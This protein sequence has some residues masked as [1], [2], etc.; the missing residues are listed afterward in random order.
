MFFL[1]AYGGLGGNALTQVKRREKK[2]KE[3]IT[4][5]KIF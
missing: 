5:K 1:V 4:D 2:G 3:K